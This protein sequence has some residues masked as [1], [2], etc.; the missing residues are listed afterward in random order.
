MQILHLP[1][2]IFPA[3]FQKVFKRMESEC[4]MMADEWKGAWL[5]G[6]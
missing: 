6:C 4:K 1:V 5:D 3:K 2:S